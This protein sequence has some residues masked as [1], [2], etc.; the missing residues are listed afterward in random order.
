MRALSDEQARLRPLFTSLL[1]TMLSTFERAHATEP[2][3]PSLLIV[4]EE[5]AYIA[6]LAGLGCA[7]LQG[8]RSGNSTRPVWQ[9]LAQ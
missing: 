6:P 4:L 9:D 2:V 3:D 7:C 8:R 5:A 1:Q